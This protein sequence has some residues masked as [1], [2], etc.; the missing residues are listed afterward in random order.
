M[1]QTDDMSIVCVDAAGNVTFDIQGKIQSTADSLIQRIWVLMLTGS[2]TLF[3]SCDSSG[4]ADGFCTPLDMLKGCNMPDDDILE[5]YMLTFSSNAMSQLDAESKALIKDLSVYVESG[6]VQ[7]LLSLENG[8]SSTIQI[9]A[10]E[11]QRA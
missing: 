5:S 11:L 10:Y 8:E 9:D 1:Q 6:R 3:R 4:D 2:N 7:M